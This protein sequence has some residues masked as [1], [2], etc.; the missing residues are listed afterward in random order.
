[1][2]ASD[3]CLLFR[4]K[5]GDQDRDCDRGMTKGRGGTGCPAL[6]APCRQPMAQSRLNVPSLSNISSSGWK[7]S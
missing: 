7:T 1:M 2:A 3:H 6:P 4:G 5:D